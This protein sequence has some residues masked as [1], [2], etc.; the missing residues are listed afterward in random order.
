M[1]L[2]ELSVCLSGG[3]CLSFFLPLPSPASSVLS[4]WL[5]LS[6]RRPHSPRLGSCLSCSPCVPMASVMSL[7]SCSTP[8]PRE[9]HS[10]CTVLGPAHVHTHM[11]MQICTHACAHACMRVHTCTCA[12]HACSHTGNI[13]LGKVQKHA[14]SDAFVHRVPCPQGAGEISAHLPCTCSIPGALH[15]AGRRWPWGHL[16]VL[17]L[18]SASLAHV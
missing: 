7:A 2:S 17:Q 12:Q 18:S 16:E 6:T 4:H 9:S 10:C 5:Q 15:C 3:P 8:T 13:S 11:D 1:L 14:S